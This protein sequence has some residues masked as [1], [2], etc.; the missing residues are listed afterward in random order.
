MKKYESGKGSAYL[1]KAATLFPDHM[2]LSHV[3]KN[4][5]KGVFSL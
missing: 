5:E 2:L 3:R 4:Y 1:Q